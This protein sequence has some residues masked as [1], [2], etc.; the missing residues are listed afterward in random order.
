MISSMTSVA[1]A[2]RRGELAGER[3]RLI[4]LKGRGVACPEVIN[5]QEEQEG[6]CLAQP[7]PVEVLAGAERQ[8]PATPSHRRHPV[9]V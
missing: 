8:S 7:F 4:W 5:W 6:A 1:P 9:A 2:S 3:D